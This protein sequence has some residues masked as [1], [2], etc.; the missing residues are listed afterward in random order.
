METPNTTPLTRPL[1]LQE[2]RDLTNDG[3]KH[4]EVVIRVD[5]SD[6]I[7]NDME[8][9]NDIVNER[10]LP[11]GWVAGLADLGYGVYDHTKAATPLS[12]GDGSVLLHVSADAS[13]V[14]AEM[15]AELDEGDD[16]TKEEAV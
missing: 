3:A 14:V 6:L 10:A 11:E 9:L 15:V 4:L 16:S 1:T 8:W 13:D 12:W 7:E 2:L 5:L